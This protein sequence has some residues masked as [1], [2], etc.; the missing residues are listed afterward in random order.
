MGA[1]VRSL[2]PGTSGV[3]G[4]TSPMPWKGGER[5]VVYGWLLPT[6]ASRRLPYERNVRSGFEFMA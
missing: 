2:P 3:A 6:G 1:W 4:L 5:R